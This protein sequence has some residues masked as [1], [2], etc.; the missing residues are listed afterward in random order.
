MHCIKGYSAG[1][2]ENHFCKGYNPGSNYYSG[3]EAITLR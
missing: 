1:K 2:A 3:E